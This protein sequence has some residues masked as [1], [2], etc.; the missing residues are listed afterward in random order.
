MLNIPTT[1][2]GEN[3]WDR[4]FITS[5][6]VLTD[7]DF[8]SLIGDNL[9]VRARLFHPYYAKE[10]KTGTSLD[11]LIDTQLT[12]DVAFERYKN[13]CGMR[14]LS[15]GPQLTMLIRWLYEVLRANQR[16]AQEEEEEG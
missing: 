10:S 4:Y 12:M 8:A 1:A 2:N 3:Q 14:I 16:P 9:K 6:T 11:L 7:F 15:E 13:I 5:I